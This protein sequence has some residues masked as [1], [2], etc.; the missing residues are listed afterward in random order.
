MT[1]TP[2]QSCTDNNDETTATSNPVDAVLDHHH[3][4]YRSQGGPCLSLLWQQQQSNNDDDDNDTDTENNQA[5]F[6]GSG[7]ADL[8]YAIPGHATRVLCIDT[9]TDVVYPIG[10]TFPIGKLKWRHGIR[11][12]IDHVIYGI[13]CHANTVL[14]IDTRT[15]QVTTL[16]IPYTDFYTN[17]EAQG[18]RDMNYKY[19]GGVLRMNSAATGSSESAAAAIYCIPQSAWH[20][21]KIDTTTDTCS[22]VK[23]E[24][25][26]KGKYKWYGGILACKDNAIYGIP[27]NA[28]QVLRISC[29]DQIT[30]HGNFKGDH[31]WHGASAVAVS[32]SEGGT[33]VCV[34]ANSNSVLCIEPSSN[35]NNDDDTAPPI[36]YELLSDVIQTGRHRKDGNYKYLGSCASTENECVYCFPSGAEYVLKV[37]TYTKTVE[38][39]GPNLVEKERIVQNKWQN[40]MILGDAGDTI[41]AIPLAAESVLRIRTGNNEVTTWMLPRP[42]DGMAKWDGAVVV[43]STAN[44]SIY[45]MPNNHKAVLRISDTTPSPVA[46]AADKHQSMHTATRSL[47]TST[48]EA[49]ALMAPSSATSTTPT[50]ASKTTTPTIVKYFTA[51]VPKTRSSAQQQQQQQRTHTINKYSSSST[52]TLKYTTGI[53]TLR[54]SAHRVKYSHKDRNN[55]AKGTCLPRN[56]CEN[57]ILDYDLTKF[58]FAV[59]LLEFLKDCDEKIVGTFSSI[60]RLEHFQIPIEAL[61]RGSIGGHCE[62]AQVYL[63]DQLVAYE[64]FLKLFDEFVVDCIL[65]HLKQ[66]L[67][68]DDNDNGTNDTSPMQFFYQRPPTLRLQP[69]PARAFVR[70]HCDAEY[71]HQEG[72]LNFWFPLT[73]RQ[74]T[75][76]D[77]HVEEDCDDGDD[78]GDCI[79]VPIEMGQILSFHG[80]NRKHFVNSNDTVFTRASLDF[81][82]GVEGYFD[83]EWEM[84]G[85]TND[86]TRRRVQV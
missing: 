55:K 86:H 54:S 76:V 10:P 8:I 79:A 41:Y 13:P 72:E 77:L 60:E 15:Q 53:P 6:K 75:K 78:D 29:Q 27:Y 85:T 20:V 31:K 2:E 36:L 40:G 11:V 48:A 65:P 84:I 35:S 32:A 18:Q 25:P 49:P 80:T 1:S 28:K 30:L 38:T 71:G 24:Q 22:F 33:I 9:K 34:P 43:A 12:N 50:T 63:S 70:P 19:H 17:G 57:L 21:L 14:R 42:F 44:N 67:I 26:L 74:I 59:V 58:D 66:R 4:D 83:S 51:D 5:Q 73:D 39:I 52:T 62:Q 69:G 81:R 46:I 64:P 47:P 7:E 61:S 56:I 3:V 45:C 37:N 23:S 82:V 16:Q 68:N